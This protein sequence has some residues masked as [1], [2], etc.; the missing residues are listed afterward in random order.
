MNSPLAPEFVDVASS[1]ATVAAHVQR[2]FGYDGT[3]QNN[4]PQRSRPRYPHVC[5][6]QCCGMCSADLAW[7][8]VRTAVNNLDVK[9]GELNCRERGTLIQFHAPDADPSPM[10]FVGICT[11]RPTAMHILMRAD[12]VG[13]LGHLSCAAPGPA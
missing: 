10:Y 2:L 1:D 9:L 3:V 7:P 12:P 8:S 13:A 11:V 4:P 5:H 6:I